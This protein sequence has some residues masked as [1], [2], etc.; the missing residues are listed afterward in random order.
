MEQ[1]DCRSAGCQPAYW[2]ASCPRSIWAYLLLAVLFFAGC[3]PA[4]NETYVAEE[5]VP[6][7][8]QSVLVP[9]VMATAASVLP[10][11]SAT[12]A[13]TTV[14]SPTHTP[15]NT[16]TPSP[17]PTASSTP[18]PSPTPTIT[19]WPT[20][21]RLVLPEAVAAQLPPCVGRTVSDDL[22]EIVTQQFSLPRS[23]TPA[24]LKPLADYFGYEVTRGF[25]TQI[26]ESVAQPLVDIVTAMESEGLRPSILSG[27]RGYVEQSMAWDM[28]MEKYPDRAAIISARPGYSEHQL[29]TTVDFG[30]P[31]LEHKFHTDF[32]YTSEGVW[33]AEN[34]YLYGFTLSYPQNAFELTGFRHEAWHYRYVGV[35]MAMFLYTSQLTLTEWQLAERPFPCIP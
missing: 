20:V 22:L 1:L 31:E 13:P 26:R 27:Y 5:S 2:R 10:Q 28:W 14:P 9:T 3:R 24:G 18:T 23:Y 7:R 16:S 34:A 11:A 32:E 33:L 19:P 4:A 8:M 21:T 29:G 6:T 17:V 35:E 15:T 30:S 25:N 12:I